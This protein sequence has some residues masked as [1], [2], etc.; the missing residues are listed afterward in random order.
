MA[1]RVGEE[2]SSLL[3]DDVRSLAAPYALFLT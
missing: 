3:G 2:P 1:T